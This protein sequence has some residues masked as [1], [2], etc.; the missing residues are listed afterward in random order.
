VENSWRYEAGIAGALEA[1]SWAGHR[2]PTVRAHFHA[3]DQFTFVLSGTRS[4]LAAGSRIEIHAGQCLAIPAGIPHRSLSEYFPNTRCINFY[5]APHLELNSP[6]IF[7]VPGLR[8]VTSAFMTSP[9]W[10]VQLMGGNL[11]ETSSRCSNQPFSR[12]PPGRIAEIA[13][14][15]GM[16]REG[17]TRRYAREFGM[18][19]HARR[20]I[21]RLNDARAMLRGG[22]SL[23]GVAAELGFADQ[24]HFGRHFRAAFGAAPGA[25]RVGATQSQS[26]QT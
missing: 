16:S 10:L 19:P 2:A 23:A 8:D 24:S 1:A 9:G 25:Y 20:L 17:F 11:P 3:D 15:A 21:I 26:F 4:F 5:I 6:L 12:L 18:P 14:V 13:T 7:D 22:E